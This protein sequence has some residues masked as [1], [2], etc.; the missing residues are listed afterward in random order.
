MTQPVIYLRSGKYFL[1]FLRD[2]EEGH[3]IHPY[4]AL[5]SSADPALATTLAAFV[6]SVIH[7]GVFH[8]CLHIVNSPSESRHY[9]A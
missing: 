4:I 9:P 3:N 8:I 2:F 1:F 6:S 7:P 5:N